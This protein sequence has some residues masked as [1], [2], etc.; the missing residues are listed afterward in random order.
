M[1]TNGRGSGHEWEGEWSRMGGGVITNGRGSGHKWEGEWSRMGGAN[2]NKELTCAPTFSSMHSGAGHS[3]SSCFDMDGS[4]SC[5]V[6]LYSCPGSAESS[7]VLVLS[8]C[9]LCVHSSVGLTP[10]FSMTACSV[11][12]RRH[13][14]AGGHLCGG[15]REVV[16]DK[17]GGGGR[18]KVGGRGK[19]G[20]GRGKGRRMRRERNGGRER[21][22]RRMRR[23]GGRGK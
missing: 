2:S 12:L 8:T 23:G 19:E 17:E 6:N 9:S 7:R 4:L 10:S 20:G 16:R 5:A 22:G 14:M 21:E 13:V 15:R 3:A 1:V 18:G 11:P